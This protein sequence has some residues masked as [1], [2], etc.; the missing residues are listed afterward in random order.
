MRLDGDA[1]R[2]VTVTLLCTVAQL[3]E[4][5]PEA[6]EPIERRAPGHT[7]AE[8]AAEFERLDCRGWQEWPYTAGGVLR[9]LN[10]Y[11]LLHRENGLRACGHFSARELAATLGVSMNTVW[12]LGELG[13][14]QRENAS[15]ETCRNQF[16]YFEPDEATVENFLSQKWKHKTS[17]LKTSKNEKVGSTG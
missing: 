15:L 11:C 12:C 16:L 4:A 8:I 2:T 5:Q 13:L 14:L 7:P 10:H 17:G 6:L 9:I 3:R 1:V